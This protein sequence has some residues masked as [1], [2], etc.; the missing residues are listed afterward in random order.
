MIIVK[1]EYTTFGLLLKRSTLTFVNVFCCVLRYCMDVFFIYISR[2]KRD[3][4]RFTVLLFLFLYA[5]G[6]TE[7]YN[8]HSLV[9][10]YT[11]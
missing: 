5:S 4:D 7:K 9:C 3:L 8:L 10:L 1:F 11:L 6:L 2:E